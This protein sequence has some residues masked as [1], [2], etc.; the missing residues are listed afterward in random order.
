MHS[1]SFTSRKL[2]SLGLLQNEVNRLTK[3]P[4]CYRLKVLQPFFPLLQAVFSAAAQLTASVLASEEK[5]LSPDEDEFFICQSGSSTGSVNEATIYAK[6][7]PEVAHP[8]ETGST[9]TTLTS[10]TDSL[11]PVGDHHPLSEV[12]VVSEEP[13][14]EE[15]PLPL[16]PRQQQAAS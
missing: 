14:G 13:P 7:S 15:T 11:V 1:R 8:A 10:V 6:D 2:L 12:V 16:L 9:K 4:I 5:R 3:T